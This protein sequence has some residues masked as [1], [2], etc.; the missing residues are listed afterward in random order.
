MKVFQ[1]RAV[2]L[3]AGLVPIEPEQIRAALETPPSL[4]MGN[5]AFPCF[6]L[7]KELKWAPAKIATDLAEKV[8]KDPFFER[9]D[10]RGP[11]LNFFAHRGKLAEHTVGEILSQGG[12][13]GRSDQG[14]GQTVV[15]D[16]SAPNIAKPFGVGHLRSTIIG[17]SLYRIHAAL[18]YQCVGINYI[19]DWGT[20]FGKL[21]AAFRRWGDEEKLASDPIQHLYE[22]YVGF[23]QEAETDPELEEEGRAWFKKLEE[24]DPAAR[25]LWRRFREISLAEFRRVYALLGM[26]FDYWHGESFYNDLLEA[27]IA[28]VEQAGLLERSQGALVVSL[29]DEG[30]P[31]CLLRKQDGATLYHTRDLAAAIYR[32]E[33]WHFAK[34]LY[35]VGVDQTLHF[36]QLFAVLK[37]MGLDWVEKCQHV[38]FGMIRYG[39]GKMSTRQGRLVFL[40]DVLEEATHRARQIIA[41]KN[42][43]LENREETARQVGVGALIFGDLSNDR[44]KDIDF[45]WDQV[46]DFSGETAPYIQYAHAR[47]CSILRKAPAEGEADLALLQDEYEY[48]LVA[49]LSRFP[50]AIERAGD[51]CKP[52]FVARYLIEV[53]KEFSRF[54]H[55]CPV[56]AAEPGARAARLALVAAVRQVLANGLYLLGI[57]A[58][59]EM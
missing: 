59:Q 1:E 28:A 30:M 36:R 29:E 4:E 48:P 41:A 35:V 39:G 51:T 34:A 53:A 15:L 32:H 10:V 44:I 19:G 45:D 52:S 21:I 46:M 54:Y 55:Q 8:G 58:P 13:Y 17:N 56:L 49:A 24:G 37:K 50:E 14:G 5:F 57:E 16:Y 18:G 2:R 22:L 43:D 7:A 23:H 26:E 42:P 38:P 31:P 12:D 25:E 47:I 9:V 40:A 6:L 3:L 27:A 11:Y 33:T 20:Q